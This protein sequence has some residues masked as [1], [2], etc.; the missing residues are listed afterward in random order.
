M[1]SWLCWIGFSRLSLLSL[2]LYK[3]LIHHG[4]LNRCCLSD[5]ILLIYIIRILNILRIYLCLLASSGHILYILIFINLGFLGFLE[6]RHSFIVSLLSWF[7]GCSWPVCHWLHLIL[8]WLLI[9]FT[10]DLTTDSLMAIS[11]I[12]I[13]KTVSL[14]LEVVWSLI[15]LNHTYSSSC[16]SVCMSLLLCW[17]VASLASMTLLVM[18]HLSLHF[19]YFF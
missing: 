18:V 11:S 17:T 15:W 3:G 1:S 2:G 16:G 13:K 12:S 10:C 5:I 4:L 8:S 9:S 14:C 7:Q 19:F 6:K